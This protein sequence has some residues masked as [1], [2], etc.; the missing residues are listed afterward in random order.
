MISSLSAI[1]A[2]TTQMNVVSNN[3]ANAD[4]AGFKASQVSLESG[5]GQSV[6]ASIVQNNTPGPLIPVYG[7]GGGTQEA[8]N[9]NPVQDITQ[10]APVQIGYEV[11]MRVIQ[12][13]SD[14][15]GA[16]INLIA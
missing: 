14:M 3:I 4:T 6:N 1:N 2:F 8:S 5:P 15:L 13:S 11:N 16:I 10:M 12:I 7:S 9:E